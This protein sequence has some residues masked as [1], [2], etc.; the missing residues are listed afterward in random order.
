M[1][2]QT[3][4]VAGEW[5]QERRETALCS[6]SGRQASD[7]QADTD[8]RGALPALHAFMC[9]VAR[10]YVRHD[11]WH[12]RERQGKRMAQDM[13]HKRPEEQAKEATSCNA[14]HKT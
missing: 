9:H 12:W 3:T 10:R 1:Q 13:S 5:R 8:I 4:A 11:S 7:R 14:M 6:T 2:R